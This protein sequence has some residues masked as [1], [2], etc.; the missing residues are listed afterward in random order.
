MRPVLYVEV[1]V[2]ALKTS[3]VCKDDLQK[4]FDEYDYVLHVNKGPR[5]S[6][7]D[8]FEILETASLNDYSEFFD[9]MAIH[10]ES[11]RRP[12]ND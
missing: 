9:V 12:V 3:G 7:N 8:T 11:E 2:S 6:A 1:N 5:N 4:F 10:Q